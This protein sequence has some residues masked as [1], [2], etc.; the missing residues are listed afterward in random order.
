MWS[1]LAQPFSPAT[2]FRAHDCMVTSVLLIQTRTKFSKTSPFGKRPN[3]HKKQI[4][5]QKKSQQGAYLARMSVARPLDRPII[6]DSPGNAVSS[7]IILYHETG[8]F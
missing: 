1:F 4:E 5:E 8:K 7:F 2:I 3:P 6:I